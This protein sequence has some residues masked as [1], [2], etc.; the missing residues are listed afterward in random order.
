M[1]ATSLLVSGAIMA[2]VSREHLEALAAMAE[3][4]ETRGLEDESRALREILAQINSGAHEVSES[5]AAEVLHV[6][7]DI[8][9]NWVRAGILAG[10][11]DET[12][13]LYVPLEVL[14][15]TIRLSLAMPDVSEQLAAMT[16][17]EIN[18]EIEAVRAERR[19]TAAKE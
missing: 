4:L 2:I 15:P 17:D 12:G 16:D 19:L 6:P 13:R 11:E 14:E 1:F 8:V 5:T 9:R 10:R 18:A 3:R 7:P